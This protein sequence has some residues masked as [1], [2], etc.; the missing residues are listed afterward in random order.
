MSTHR[1]AS[2]G[3]HNGTHGSAFHAAVDGDLIG[4]SPADLLERILSANRIIRAE[5]IEI[6]AGAGHHQDARS[7]R[8][9]RARAQYQEHRHG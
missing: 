5:L 3:T 7:V 9:G 1:G 6:L 2:R 8:H 4:I